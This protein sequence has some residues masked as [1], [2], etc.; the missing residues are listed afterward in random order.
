MTEITRV[1]LQPLTKGS[2]VR[3]W[4]G[5]L[6][7]ILLALGGARAARIMHF[8]EVRVTAIKEGTGPSP[9]MQDVVMINY[10]GHLV[11]GKVFDQA[12]HT[13]MPVAGVVPGFSQGLMK[14]KAGGKYRLEIPASLAYGAEAKRDPRSGDLVIPANS[15]L[16][17]EVELIGSMPAQQFQQLM[18]MEQ[19]RQAQAQKNAGGA[20][21]AVPPPG[22]MPGQ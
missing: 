21:A 22:A 16:V 8:S 12:Q 17:F 19:A 18:M 2:L 11:S 20:G 4:L 14:M 5:V 7:V 9:T 13:P 1:P 6:A 10:V 3:L 15:D